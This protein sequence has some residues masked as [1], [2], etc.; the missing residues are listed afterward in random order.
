M[1]RPSKKV[2]SMFSEAERIAECLLELKAEE[3]RLRGSL[4]Q[5]WRTRAAA[6]GRLADVAKDA[7]VAENAERTARKVKR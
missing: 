1:P 6:M 3:E 4:E 5:V 7:A 2:L